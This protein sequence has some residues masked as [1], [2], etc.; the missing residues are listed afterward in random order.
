MLKNQQIRVISDLRNEKIGFKIREHTLQ[1]VPYMIVVGDREVEQNTI[2]V[3]DLGGDDLRGNHLIHFR[4]GE[5]LAGELVD[6]RVTEFSPV[7]LRG[8]LCR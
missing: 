1:R 5:E 8:E 4:G 6:V 3:R 2:A 7:S